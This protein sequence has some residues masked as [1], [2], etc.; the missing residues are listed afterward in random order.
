MLVIGK[1]FSRIVSLVEN[2]YYNLPL[3]SC[4]TMSNAIVRPSFTLHSCPTMSNAMSNAM[5]LAT[6]TSNLA[7]PT[8]RTTQSSVVANICD[9]FIQRVVKNL[10]ELVLVLLPNSHID[11]LPT[12]YFCWFFL[13]FNID[14]D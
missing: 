8:V 6:I 13:V 1:T 3:H 7:P 12:S 10:Q 4:P 14:Y 5:I 2:V 11:T 9:T